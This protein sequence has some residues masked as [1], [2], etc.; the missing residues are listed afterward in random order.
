MTFAR[1][2]GNPRCPISRGNLKG[3]S[4][5]IDHHVGL[6]LFH[7]PNLPGAEMDP[8]LI[9]LPVV[10]QSAAQ[11]SANSSVDGGSSETTAG[12]LLMVVQFPMKSCKL[13]VSGTSTWPDNQANA[14]LK[15]FTNSAGSSS[16]TLSASLIVP[17]HDATKKR[18]APN[19][20]MQLAN[21]DATK[22]RCAPNL[23]M[24]LAN[25][26]ATKKRCAPNLSMQLARIVYELPQ[27]TDVEFAAAR[28]AVAMHCVADGQLG[29][30]L[31]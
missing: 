28:V 21:H 10:T 27:T 6:C 12:R 1:I 3:T 9:T 29:D 18:C 16:S 17:H 31:E 23:S 15:N 11:G 14:A 20:S 2:R 26:D 7:Q 5:A 19:L 8:Y 13:R 30:E 24:Q 25:H 4:C 22:K